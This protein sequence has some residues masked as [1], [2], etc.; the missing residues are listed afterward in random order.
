M[1]SERPKTAQ[2]KIKDIAERFFLSEPLLFATF[3]TH[4]L[5]ENRSLKIPF[6]TGQMRLEYS[7]EIVAALSEKQ[8]EEYLTAELFRILLKHPYQRVPL[9]PDM[10]L[11][12]VASDITVSQ[13]KNFSISLP[14]AKELFMKN[15]L[16]YE[17]YYAE[18]KNRKDY[19]MD[20]LS[21]GG[22]N[23]EEFLSRTSQQSALWAEDEE[24]SEKINALIKKAQATNGWGTIPGKAIETIEASLVVCMDYRHILSQFRA[25]ILSQDRVLTRMRPNRRYGFS[26]MGSRYSFTTSLLVA[27]DVSGSVSSE[28]LQRFFSVINSFFKYGIKSIDVIQFDYGVKEEILTLKKARKK[29]KVLGRGGTSFQP[30]VDFY[31]SHKEYDGLIVCT[32]GFAPC[33]K[34]KTSRRILWMLTDECA[35]KENEWLCSL[36]G[37]RAVWVP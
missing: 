17:E 7:Q 11:L 9:Y 36:R 29:V 5:E 32:D 30:P 34:R 12:P 15:G 25:S 18:L 28:D 26:Y 22:S 20:A 13:M 10:N 2:E 24:A 16:S 37:S 3:C 14:S 31:E 19:A 27:V 33:P 4:T 1:K 35:L 23:L 8:T 21:E 6:R